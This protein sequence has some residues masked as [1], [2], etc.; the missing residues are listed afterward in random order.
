M[1]ISISCIRAMNGDIF[2]LGRMTTIRALIKWGK[3]RCNN[4][5]YDKGVKYREGQ[6]R[7]IRDFFLNSIK[8]FK[9][10]KKRNMFQDI[11]ED[12]ISTKNVP[13]VNHSSP[14]CSLWLILMTSTWREVQ[15]PAWVWLSTWISFKS[16][17]YFIFNEGQ[18]LAISRRTI[19]EKKK[20]AVNCL[21]H[22]T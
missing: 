12:E 7:H 22:L 15:E 14:P 1:R 20:L 8:R 16:A 18:D 3:K 9:K 10:K 19:K 6:R 13:S 2:K 5:W 4:R 11:R 21:C 17:N